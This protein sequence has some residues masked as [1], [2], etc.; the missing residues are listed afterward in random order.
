M[1]D[2][3]GYT[4]LSQDS[5]TSIPRQRENIERYC[6]RHEMALT[7]VYDEGEYASGY[8]DV[9]DRPKYQEVKREML[10]GAVDAVVVNDRQRLGR[11]FDERMRFVLDLR[12]TEVDL[13]TAKE[14]PVDLSD[15]REVV[16]ESMRAAEDDLAK[17]AEIEKAKEAT[18]ERL[19]NG[20]DHGR[21]PFG[22]QYDDA[23]EYWVPDRESGDYSVAVETIERR[24]TGESF[25]SIARELDGLSDHNQARR[26]WHRRDRYMEEQ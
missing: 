15:P 8:D 14:G 11:D 4:R 13:H 16:L 20:F 18:Q 5:Q 1:S 21:P 7:A 9:D 24:E 26:I 6:E 3:I 19:D 12:A 17:R 22:L 23:G 25:R 10:A 2:A